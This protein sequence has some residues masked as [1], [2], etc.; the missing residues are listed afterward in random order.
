MLIRRFGLIVLQEGYGFEKLR[1][2]RRTSNFSE[3]RTAQSKLGRC[4]QVPACGVRRYKSSSPHSQPESA[5]EPGARSYGSTKYF[6]LK[7]KLKEHGQTGI[8]WGMGDPLRGQHIVGVPAESRQETLAKLYLVSM[9]FTCAW[10]RCGMTHF[11]PLLESVDRLLEWY[12]MKI[13]NWYS[14]S[15]QQ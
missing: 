15:G 5:I 7:G 3:R 10:F 13:L 2:R 8:I 12:A 14:T 4:I 9:S 1:G 11:V 6:H